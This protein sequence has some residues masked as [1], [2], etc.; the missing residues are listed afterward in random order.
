MVGVMQN[1][2][3]APAPAFVIG[4]YAAMPSGCEGQERFYRL[5]REQEWVDGLEIP[6]PGDLLSRPEWLAGELAVRWVAN[7]ITAI[8]GT[9]KNLQTNPWFG[10]ASPDKG[11]RAAALKF[12]ELIRVAVLRLA[13]RIGHPVVKYVQ[14]HS[15]PTRHAQ[16]RFLAASLAEV[17]ARDWA[18]AG[19]VIEH[20]DRYVPGQEPEKGFMALEDEIQVAAE[21]DV[22]I[23]I[24]WGRSCI[25]ARDPGEALQGISEARSRGMLSG[26]IFSGASAARTLYGPAW[27]DAHL[28]ATPDE[29]T[30]LMTREAMS[31]CALAA[32]GPDFP[33]RP[34]DYLGAK[35]SVPP[36]LPLH[37]RVQIIRT[38]FES[39]TVGRH[40]A[41][42]ASPRSG[43]G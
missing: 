13:D 1:T 18:G 33:G 7:T 27:A 2:G 16:S 3:A 8:P 24:N 17:C 15:A 9:M 5:L 38:V 29:P 41:E 40:P 14:I 23:H 31:H 30:S 22:R 37:K 12:T 10:L 28:P 36:D 19:L 32:V 42:D 11:G 39:T 25:E 35:I 21:S 43:T 26:V 34:A 4:A 20:C 6:F